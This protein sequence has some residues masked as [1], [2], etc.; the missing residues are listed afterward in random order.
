M[1]LIS[2]V[3]FSHYSERSGIK[4]YLNRET[5]KILGDSIIFNLRRLEIK[6]PSLDAK[7]YLSIRKGTFSFFPPSDELDGYLGYYNL[8]QKDEDT[9]IFKKIKEDET[10]HDKLHRSL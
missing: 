9:F 1:K 7:K 8:Y 4:C 3:E 6:R 5:V 10:T 2:K